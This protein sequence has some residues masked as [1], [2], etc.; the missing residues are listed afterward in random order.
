MTVEADVRNS[1]LQ[2]IYDLWIE[3]QVL[4]VRLDGINDQ[5]YCGEA[6]LMPGDTA[7]A[8]VP[9][10]AG[11][12]ADPLQDVTAAAAFRDH[13]GVWWR[14]DPNGHVEEQPV[15]PLVTLAPA[16]SAPPDGKASDVG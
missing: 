6:P 16:D 15:R 11:L 7:S 5:T 10:E 14:T 13:A 12:M 1:S 9:A 4:T 8:R 3:W 2:P